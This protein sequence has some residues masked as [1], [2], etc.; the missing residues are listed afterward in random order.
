MGSQPPL[1]IIGSP[2]HQTNDQK[3]EHFPT[4]KRQYTITKLNDN[5]NMKS[6]IAGLVNNY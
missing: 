5:I 2:S 3:R 4:Q 6:T 1:L